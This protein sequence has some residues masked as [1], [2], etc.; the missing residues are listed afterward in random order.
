MLDLTRRGLVGAIGLG[1]V[2]LP[3]VGL[4]AAQPFFARTGLPIGLQLY[5]LAD[6]AKADL[7]GTLRAVAAIGFKTIELAGYQGRT[8]AQLRAAM[9]AVGLSTPSAHVQ[10]QAQ[11]GESSLDGDLS[12]LADEAHIL[13]VKRIVMPIFY[14]PAR[15]DLKPRSGEAFGQVLGRIG[16]A[17]TADDWSFNADFLNAKGAVLAKSGLRLA[18][19]NH[20]PEFRLLADGKP[21]ARTGYEILLARTDPTLVEFEMDAGWVAAA[22]QDPFALLKA[23]PGRFTA[24]HVKDIKATTK[25]NFVFVQ[26]PT[27]VGSGMIDW[28]RLLPAAYAAGVRDF[29][30]EQ[31]PPFAHSRLESVGVSYGYLAGLRA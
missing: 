11:G 17:M 30:V 28:T 23:H 2:T 15:F 10:V 5:T 12:R 14:T 26:D 13:G 21:G 6:Q 16:G 3:G 24:M 25:P 29:F 18:Y 4:A 20:N 1:A 7:E 19:H 22:G 9:D 27:E 31:E 8:P